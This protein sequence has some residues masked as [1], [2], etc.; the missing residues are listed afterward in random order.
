MLRNDI[1]TLIL[2]QNLK[3]NYP[4][5]FFDGIFDLNNKTNHP[6][7]QLCK[8]K[9]I[10]IILDNNVNRIYG[11]KIKQFFDYNRVEY[12][13]IKLNASENYKNIKT[14]VSLC[15]TAKKLGLQRDSIFIAV[16]GGIT[17][18]IVGFAAFIYR[19][20][21][22]YIRIPTTLVG[23]IDAGVGVKVG[24]NFGGSKNFLGGYYP[25]L[26]VFNDQSF[27][28]TLTSKEIRCGLFE[29]LKMAI[30]KDQKLFVLIKKYYK[31][32]F[33]KEFNSYTHEINY[34]AAFLMM[35][36]LEKNLF[37][38]NLRRIVDFGHTF[39]PFLETASSYTIPH[40]EAVGVD[41]LISSII[42]LKRKL[43]KKSEFGEIFKLIISIGFSKRYVLPNAKE[44]HDSLSEIR[45]HRS[46]NLN[47]VLPVKIG[48]AVFTN[49]CTYM[50]IENAI[51]FLLSTKLF[52]KAN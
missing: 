12:S 7:V 17:M 29:M 18:D 51:K 42:S 9:K 47:L 45:R 43:I 46:G 39:S 14:I 44:L 20:K 11:K 5:Y 28:K 25:P 27:L 50:E 13:I 32:F 1:N 16:G 21:I 33:K 8:G 34:L 48:T 6:L 49:K 30:I 3:I 4:V 26:A 35:E 10:L 22:P 24:I 19:R 38:K 37:E 52:T 2:N 23:V 15:S 41:M 31:Q 36:E 40:G